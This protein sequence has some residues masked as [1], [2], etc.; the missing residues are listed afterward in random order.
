MRNKA[1]ILYNR[2]HDTALLVLDC[3]CVGRGGGGGLG[4]NE[5]G[6]MCVKV[7]LRII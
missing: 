2:L 6:V 5:E 7:E 3:V 1:F 4:E